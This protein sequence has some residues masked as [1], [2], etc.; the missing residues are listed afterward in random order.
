MASREELL[1]GIH[2]K[3]RLDNAFFMKVYGYEISFPGFVDEAI[4]VLND[5]GCSRAKDYY[6]RAVSEYEKKHDE[7][8][9]EVA[10]WYRKECE[11]Q[12]QKRQGEGEE[13]RKQ[14]MQSRSQ[15]WKELSQILG[16]QST[17][18]EK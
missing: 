1:Q 5:A 11:K 8:M 4:K 6:D 12:W 7:E 2:P 9:K 17:K 15:K 10:A 16:F 18:K 14:K 13:Q 3:M